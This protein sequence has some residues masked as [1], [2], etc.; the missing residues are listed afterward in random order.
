MM[1]VHVYLLVE[2]LSRDLR[3][4]VGYLAANAVVSALILERS[5]AFSRAYDALG[6]RL[7]MEQVKAD[8]IDQIVNFLRI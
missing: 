8:L 2:H 7:P 5:V 1:L 3:R 4:N 6:A